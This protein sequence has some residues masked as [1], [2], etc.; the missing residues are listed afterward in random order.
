G[1]FIRLSA[2]G[3]VTPPPAPSSLAA[4]PSSGQVSLTWNASNAPSGIANY[5]VYRSTTPGFTPSTANRIAQP[6]ATSYTDIG[7]TAGTSYYKVTADDTAGNTSA[8]SNEVT[9]VV[10]S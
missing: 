7:R 4:N 9:A 3:D 5:N 6:T 1:S 10:P 2:T 8:P